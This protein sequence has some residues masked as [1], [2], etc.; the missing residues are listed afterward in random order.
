[1][2]TALLLALCRIPILC[3]CLLTCAEPLSFDFSKEQ[4]MYIHKQNPIWEAYCLYI[5]RL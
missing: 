1:M 2:A 3:V 4:Y 5:D